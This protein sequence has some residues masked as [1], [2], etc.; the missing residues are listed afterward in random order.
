MA[1]DYVGERVN[2]SSRLCNYAEGNQF[3]FDNDLYDTVKSYFK[4]KGI[5]YRIW[6]DLAEL[7]GFE[8][9]R[10]RIIKLDEEN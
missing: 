4:V 7:K 3:V 6:S 8:E 9:T 5:P 1:F 10:V 2:F